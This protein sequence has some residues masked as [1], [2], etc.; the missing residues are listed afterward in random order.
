MARPSL[1]VLAALAGALALI[2]SVL[3]LTGLL[4]PVLSYSPGNLVFAIARLAVVAYAGISF[5]GAGVKKAALNGALVALVA[6]AVICLATLAGMFVFRVP[7]MGLPAM[8]TIPLLIVLAL[9]LVANVLLGT[10]IAAGA[11]LLA[12]KRK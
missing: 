4:P 5:A 8:N 3:I 6:N 12:G 2:E 7:V 11:A 9:T 1:A 10:V